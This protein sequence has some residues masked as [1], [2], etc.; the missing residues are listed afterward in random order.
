MI[1]SPTLQAQERT[2]SGD[3]RNIEEIVVTGSRIPRRDFVSPS[4]IATIERE[5]LMTTGQPTLEG[6]LN[7][8]PQ[9][10]PDFDRTSNNPGDGTARVNLRNFGSNRTLVML[11]G[12]RLMPSGVGNSVDVN[13]VPQMLIERVEVITGGATTVYGSDAAAGVVNF[14]TRRDFDGLE[15]D[16]SGYRT[17]EGDSDTWDINA[18]WGTGFADDRGHVTLFGGWLERDATFAGARDFTSVQYFDP[19]DGSPLVERGSAQTPDGVILFPPVDLG[20]GP[21]PIRFTPEGLPVPFADPDDRYNFA[22]SNYLQIP[23][24]RLSAGLLLDYELGAALEAYAELTW[25]NNRSRQTLAPVPVA[26]GFLTNWD[27]PVLTPEARAVFRDQFLPIPQP[28]L[29]PNTV[30]Y[31]LGRRLVELGP[32]IIENDFDYTRLVA[33]LRGDIAAGWEFDVWAIHTRNEQR[34]RFTN[35]ASASRLQQA[36]FVD[37]ATGGCY[38]PSGGCVPADVFGAGRLSDAAVAFIRLD[39]FENESVRDQTVVN[40]FVRGTPF[41]MPAGGVDVVLGA[42]WR[43]DEGRLSVDPGLYEGDSLGYF[44]QAGVDG[45]ESV[46]ELYAEALV[47]LAAD[48]PGLEILNLELGARYSEYEEAGS[49]TT[50]KAGAEW[51]PVADVRFRTMFQRSVRAPNLSEA[52]QEQGR[53]QGVYVFELPS[54]D[55]CSASAQPVANGRRDAC[56]AT[57]VPADQIGVFEATPGYPVEFLFGGNPALEP[58]VAD[59]LTVGVVL[60]P[61]A[62]PDWQVAVDYFDIEIEDTI[63]ELDAT[64]VCFDTMNTGNLFCDNFTRDPGNFNVVRV[65]EP[66]VN[67]GLLRS[68]GVDTQ[69]S[70][71]TA[72]PAALALPGGSADLSVSLLWTHMLETTVQQFPGGEAWDC[73]GRYGWPCIDAIDGATYPTDR[74]TTFVGY[75]SGDLGVDVTWRYIGNVDI[76]AVPLGASLLGIEDPMPVNTGTG[77]RHYVDLGVSYDFTDGLT[78]RLVIANLNDMSPPMMANAVVSNNTDTAMYDIFGRS[79]SLGISYRF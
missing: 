14:V 56:I 3:E 28:G 42:T 63:G 21:G 20:S 65:D 74:V 55:P 70:Y 19:L 47:P 75:R 22:P 1:L 50:W 51:Q 37:P 67:R 25:T 49:A 27:S 34:Y 76:A 35:D 24:E 8:M 6:A 18:A 29:P 41:R 53:L 61:R 44:P 71:R 10:T 13:N 72:L 77:A 62:F 26:A 12:R 36:L 64:L 59:S 9:V 40:G 2:D 46:S 79:Y 30:A 52:F 11:N 58:E 5:A 60:S 68:R 23:I 31:A 4:P 32:R 78:A 7:R 17:A 15:L 66:Y 33:G 57:G 69:V 48:R 38:D 45:A 39:P 16:L 54:E 73:A 43:R